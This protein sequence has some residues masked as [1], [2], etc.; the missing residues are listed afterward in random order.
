MNRVSVLFISSPNAFFTIAGTESGS[1]KSVA[2]AVEKRRTEKIAAFFEV[3]GSMLTCSL[4][5]L[6][7]ACVH[8]KLEISFLRVG[9]SKYMVGPMTQ[10]K[11]AKKILPKNKTK[12]IFR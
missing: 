9:D 5:I 4:Q 6:I 7:K 2:I 1:E 10:P 12:L 3:N 8:K 11:K